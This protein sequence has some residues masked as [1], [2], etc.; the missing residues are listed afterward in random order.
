MSEDMSAIRSYYNEMARRCLLTNNENADALNH[1]A[2]PALTALLL[3]KLDL[4]A[5]QEVP[6]YLSVDRSF[7]FGRLPA[8]RLAEVLGVLLDNAIEAAV[9]SEAPRVNVTLSST[10]E[11]DEILISNTYAEDAEL[12]FLQGKMVSSKPGHQATGLASAAQALKRYPDICFN[13]Y[14]QG[15]YVETSLCDYKLPS[16]DRR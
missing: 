4:A 15:R 7:S 12:S 11:Y 3:R 5:G 1:I 10:E 14:L 16:A 2:D 9:K 13:Q 6:F 8:A